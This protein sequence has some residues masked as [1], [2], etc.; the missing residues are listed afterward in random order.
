[1]GFN[2]V[3]AG[4][5]GNTLEE[6]LVEFGLAGT[7]IVYTKPFKGVAVD[8]F[9]LFLRSCET[10]FASKRKAKMAMKFDAYTNS[11]VWSEDAFAY[12]HRFK[13]KRNNDC[14]AAGMSDLPIFNMSSN[15][16]EN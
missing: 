4:L 10:S 14:N 9:L 16:K 5:T 12:M 8:A 3:I 15:K 1:M 2:N 6:E 13:S 7:D 11:I